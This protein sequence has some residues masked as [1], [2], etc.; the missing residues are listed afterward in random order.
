MDDLLTAV[1][2]TKMLSVKRATVYE[3]TRRGLIPHI[4]L[5]NKI[6][7]PVA[8]INAWLER[9]TKLEKEAG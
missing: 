4:R 7:Y 6:R 1:E 3:W 8:A 2:L 5:A 9:Q